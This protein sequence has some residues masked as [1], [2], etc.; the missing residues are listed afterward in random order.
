MTQIACR[1][2][3]LHGQLLAFRRGF[4]QFAQLR[5]LDG[6][7]LIVRLCDRSS[8][9]VREFTFE[10]ANPIVKLSEGRKKLL[11]FLLKGYNLNFRRGLK[12]RS[13]RWC[14]TAAC[15]QPENENHA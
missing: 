15:R 10:I 2:V 12:R 9:A 13:R 11:P 7:E 4:S 1:G 5:F 8:F 14:G 6:E 3:E